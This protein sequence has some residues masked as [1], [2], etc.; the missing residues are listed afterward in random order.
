M[1]TDLWIVDAFATVPFTGNPAAVCLL[2]GRDWP[3][4][5]WMQ[6]VAAEMNLS[7]T[8]FVR[9]TGDCARYGLRWFTPTVEVELCGHATLASAHALREAG[10]ASDGVVVFDTL[11]RGAL[12]CGVTPDG[13]VTMDF[14]RTTVRPAEVPD[15]LR[16]A[17]AGTADVAFHL[18]G[19]DWLVALPDEAAVV[20]H[21]PSIEVYRAAHRGVMITAAAETPGVDFVS[22]FFAP[23]A[24]IDEDPV[25]GSTHCALGPYWAARLGKADLTARQVSSRGGTLGVRVTADRVQLQGHAVTVVEGRLRG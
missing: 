7:E 19:E 24:G 3:D 14:P 16:D 11:R 21:R 15:A 17:F 1:P 9:P 6:R 22:R 23:S 10:T 25:T 20:S 13:R 2:P 4:D 5:E 8:A 18:A 12:R